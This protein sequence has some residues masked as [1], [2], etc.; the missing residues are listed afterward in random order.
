M[1]ASIKTT[2][3]VVL[4]N[5]WPAITAVCLVVVFVA[6]VGIGFELIFN[7]KDDEKRKEAI[8]SFIWVVVGTVVVFGSLFITNMI[9]TTSSG[10]ADSLQGQGA[11]E[12]Q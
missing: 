5:I 6:I 7:R 8:K 1:E 12:Q 3:A 9:L 11:I 10:I 2:V 4:Q